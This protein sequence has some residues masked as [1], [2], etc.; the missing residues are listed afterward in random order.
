MN[1]MLDMDLPNDCRHCIALQRE[2]EKV[3]SLNARLID[4]LNMAQDEVDS[5]N[6]YRNDRYEPPSRWWIEAEKEEEENELHSS[7]LHPL[8]SSLSGILDG[9]ILPR[10]S[11]SATNPEP[12]KPIGRGI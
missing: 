10:E 9:D 7:L 1:T 5:D 2:L 6:I 11:K 12:D 4:E 8:H 3:K